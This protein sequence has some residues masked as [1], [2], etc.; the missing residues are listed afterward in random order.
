VLL[1]HREQAG[2][3]LLVVVGVDRR[4]FDHRVEQLGVGFGRGELIASRTGS[5]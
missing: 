4:V 5:A 1:E 2:D 3:L